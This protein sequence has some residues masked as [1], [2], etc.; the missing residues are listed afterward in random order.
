MYVFNASITFFPLNASITFFHKDEC[1]YSIS[2]LLYFFHWLL[3]RT[4]VSVLKSQSMSTLYH[5]QC[6][7]F[8]PPLRT[9]NAQNWK[10]SA[11]L[12]LPF[13]LL[14]PPARTRQSTTA[15]VVNHLGPDPGRISLMLLRQT[16]KGEMA[17][18]TFLQPFHSHIPIPLNQKGLGSLT[19]FLG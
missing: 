5:N 7:P 10:V 15:R 8:Y 19:R 13:V 16:T 12:P 9:T 1:M 14:L 4:R 11:G 6:Q 18:S 3:I 17:F 2:L